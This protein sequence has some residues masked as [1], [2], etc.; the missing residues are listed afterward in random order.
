LAGGPSVYQSIRCS[1]PQVITGAPEADVD[2]LYASKGGG[3]GGEAGIRKGPHE[4]C[5]DN[6]P[7]T[8]EGG[9]DGSGIQ[10]STYSVSKPL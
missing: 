5:H 3:F 8:H 2:P 1:R 4:Y 6:K 10:S 7:D 9:G